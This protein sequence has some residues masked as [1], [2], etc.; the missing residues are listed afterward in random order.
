MRGLCWLGYDGVAIRSE[1]IDRNW[2][3]PTKWTESSDGDEEAE[4]RSALS[5]GCL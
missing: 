4:P 2:T 1:R 5:S 3:E